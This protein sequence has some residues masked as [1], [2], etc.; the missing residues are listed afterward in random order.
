[1]GVMS[2][3]NDSIWIS[4]QWKSDTGEG[5]TIEWSI[6]RNLNNSEHDRQSRKRKFYPSSRRFLILLFIKWVVEILVCLGIFNRII[7]KGLGSNCYCKNSISQLVCSRKNFKLLFCAGI[8]MAVGVRIYIFR[9][10]RM[11]DAIL[12]RSPPRGNIKG[13]VNHFSPSLL[14]SPLASRRTSQ[15]TW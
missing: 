8:A 4:K 3:G 12:P 7:F 1:M 14:A 13:R 15:S 10:M 6:K 9:Q 2:K 11:T 5:W